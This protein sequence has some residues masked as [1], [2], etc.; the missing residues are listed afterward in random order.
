MQI[1]YLIINGTVTYFALRIPLLELHKF[2]IW[3]NYHYLTKIAVYTQFD[4]T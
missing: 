2:Y 3:E 1:G 4:S